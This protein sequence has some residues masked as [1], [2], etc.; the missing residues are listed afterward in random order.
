MCME[1]RRNGVR[2]GLAL[3][4]THFKWGTGA[5]GSSTPP[6]ENGEMRRSPVCSDAWKVVTIGAIETLNGATAGEGWVGGQRRYDGGKP[7]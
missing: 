5:L 7:F 6:H 2:E 1:V 3:S 4:P